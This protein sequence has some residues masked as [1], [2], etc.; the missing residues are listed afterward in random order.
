MDL[1]AL[2]ER[3]RGPVVTFAATIAENPSVI[4]PVSLEQ[5]PAG[6]SSS[7][8]L[9]RIQQDQFLRRF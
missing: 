4:V 2:V 5:S 1:L 7:A 3:L 6:R 9:D 8:R